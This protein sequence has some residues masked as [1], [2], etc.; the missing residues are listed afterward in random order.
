[1]TA[2]KYKPRNAFLDGVLV[3]NGCKRHRQAY[4]V[5]QP[6]RICDTCWPG[7]PMATHSK[8]ADKREEMIALSELEWG[9]R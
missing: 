8:R 9:R 1:M 2:P 5:W 3:C 7:P 6:Q 4:H